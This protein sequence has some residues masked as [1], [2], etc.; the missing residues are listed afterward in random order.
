MQDNIVILGAKNGK[1]IL[2]L[3]GQ[4]FQP[5]LMVEDVDGFDLKPMSVHIEGHAYLQSVGRNIRSIYIRVFRH[6][7]LRA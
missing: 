1:P 6:I 2:L 3:E 4:V 7:I 5:H